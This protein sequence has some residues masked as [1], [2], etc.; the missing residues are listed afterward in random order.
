MEQGKYDVVVIGSGMGGLFAGAPLA[1]WGYKTLV[2]EKRE[3]VGGRY[4][5]VD[6]EG[7]K[8]PTGGITVHLN[9]GQAKTLDEV[10]VEF[11]RVMVPEVLYRLEGKDY[12]MP[13]KG[14]VTAL[15]DIINKLE[16]DRA[17]L[18][19]GLAKAVAA[20]KVMGAFRKGIGEPEK[21]TMTFR[22]W[23]LQYT[24]NELAHG[25]FDSIANT[26]MGGHTYELPASAV[27]AFMV[28]M[29]GFR[30][31][32]IPPHGHAVEMDK[33][34]QVVRS[35]NGDVW[36]NCTATRIIVEG[37]R[38]RGVVVKKDG[39]EVEIASQVVVSNVG[40]KT[41]V[42]MAD[43]KN[44]DEEYLRLM[45]L[46]LR[47]H[48]V[49][50]VFVASDIPLWPES[51]EPAVLMVIGAR[52]VTSIVPIS[53]IIPEAAPPGQ[54]LLFAFGGPV[55]NDV[56]INVEEEEI[57][58][59]KDVKELLPLFEKHGRILSMEVRGVDHEYP[60]MRTRC[61]FGLP[62]E[63]TVKNLFNV[64]DACIALGLSGGTS[65]ADSGRRVAEIIRK[66]YKPEKP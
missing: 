15:L 2:V 19:G 7:F 34:A 9:A 46:R 36:T 35:S 55:T 5:T 31:V 39:S 4:S 29:G 51:G 18:L 60:E 50:V 65:A 53:N 48:P 32:G 10:G 59:L 25:V 47:P 28:G 45:R 44:F 21:E 43:E 66:S 22:D 54:H 24:D 23:L 30:E 12:Q 38:A 11:E 63:T 56:Q 17:K 58:T 40:P 57:Q 6:Y 62:V 20:E 13:S 8:L 61:G 64:G 26:L 1:H 37:G 3:R 52:R 49:T 33:L 27:F 41:T 42:A 14:S 16:I